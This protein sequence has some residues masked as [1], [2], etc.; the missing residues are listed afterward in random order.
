MQTDPRSYRSA[1]SLF[2][3]QGKIDIGVSHTFFQKFNTRQLFRPF[4]HSSVVS[5]IRI[6]LAF[7][8]ALIW[9][10]A[11]AAK[12]NRDDSKLHCLCFFVG[13]M[14]L[15]TFKPPCS[16]TCLGVRAWSWWWCWYASLKHMNNIHATLEPI[17]RNMQHNIIYIHT[18]IHIYKTT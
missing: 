5:I 7:S 8:F 4:G 18:Y 17:F 11:Q 3:S 12:T 9:F 14:L 10:P 16:L 2:V 15:K 13:Y 6:R 1:C